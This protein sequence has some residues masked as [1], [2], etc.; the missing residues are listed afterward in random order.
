MIVY[1]H[2]EGPVAGM[3]TVYV[4]KQETTVGSLLDEAV[5]QFGRGALVP[6]LY[7]LVVGG[8][9]IEDRNHKVRPHELQRFVAVPT[10]EG[11]KVIHGI[12]NPA[13]APQET[14][15]AEAPEDDEVPE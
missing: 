7:A 1:V 4:D 15:E 5:S 2:R 9:E 14:E 8:R 13:V 11:R 3:A 10:E 6:E 12:A